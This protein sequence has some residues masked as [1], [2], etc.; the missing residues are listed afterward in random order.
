MNM[1]ATA[2]DM[3]N[4]SPQIGFGPEPSCDSEKAFSLAAKAKH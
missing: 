1:G 2:R 4:E 3:G